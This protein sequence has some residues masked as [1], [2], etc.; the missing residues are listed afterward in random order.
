[1][2]TWNSD[3][4]RPYRIM[5]AMR[6]A[7][8]P[9][10]LEQLGSLPFSFDPPIGGR[11][12][13]QW[14]Y[15]RCTWDEVLVADARTGEEIAI[16]RRFLGSVSTLDDC[17]IFVT[18]PRRLEARDGVALPAERRV[19]AMPAPGETGWTSIPHASP[20]SV[21]PIRLQSTGRSVA[22]RALLYA[23]AIGM[24]VSVLYAYLY[25]GEII[26]THAPV[27]STA[28]SARF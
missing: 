20:A 21:V 7:P 4:L 15:S 27:H 12:T 10:P 17:G 2:S 1:M 23:L 18:L 19:V 22:A 13:T 25:R 3:L 16:P 6:L 9:Q 24:A 26:E 28:R 5:V 14:R 8:A 11:E